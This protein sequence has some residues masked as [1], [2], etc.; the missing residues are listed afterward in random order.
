MLACAMHVFPQA[1]R[2]FTSATMLLLFLSSDI[3]MTNARSTL[4][5]DASR[6]ASWWGSTPALWPTASGR[7]TVAASKNLAELS[8]AKKTQE[9]TQ[10][11]TKKNLFMLLG[12]VLVPFV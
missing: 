9:R 10:R 3:P 12:S 2:I 11:G 5:R 8:E 7:S 1:T 4:S 6:R